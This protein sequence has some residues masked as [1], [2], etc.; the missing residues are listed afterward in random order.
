M[1]AHA[2]RSIPAIM[3]AGSTS[4][5]NG[6]TIVLIEQ[7]AKQAL[8]ISDGLVLEQGQ[9]ASRQRRQIFADPQIAQLFLRCGLA[10]VGT[11]HEQA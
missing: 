1:K 8:R 2:L 5:F 10:P 4:R 9:P 3:H 7:N 6:I 11:C